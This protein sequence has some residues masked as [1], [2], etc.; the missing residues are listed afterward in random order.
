MLHCQYEN[1]IIILINIKTGK[2]VIKHYL[3][4]L[5]ITDCHFIIKTVLHPYVQ[6]YNFNTS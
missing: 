3:I 4:N 5:H 1:I 6:V 2:I